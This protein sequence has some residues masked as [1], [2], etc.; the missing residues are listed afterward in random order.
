M[1]P[2]PRPRHLASRRTAEGG[3]RAFADGRAFRPELH[4]VRGLALTLVVLF[5][6]LG[7]GR[8]SG[9]ID[10]FLAVTGFLAFP[11]LLRRSDHRGAVR[12]GPRFSGLVRRLLVPAVPVL[13]FVTIAGFLLLPTSA[14]P[15]LL[16]EVRASALF[17]E[18]WELVWSQ[19]AYGAAGPG[20]SPLQ[21]FWSLS[22]QGQFHVVAPLIVMAVTV[23]LVRRGR[24]P[25]RALVRVLTAVSLLSFAW[26]V[27]ATGQNQQA[28]YFSTFARAWELTAPGAVALALPRWR[29]SARWRLV[30]GW[31][32]LALIV[33]CGFALDGGRVF[34]GYLALWPVLGVLL[35]L[36]GGESRHPWGADV[37]LSS[38]PLAAV[39]DISYSLYLWHWPILILTLAARGHTSATATDAVAVIALSVAVAIASTALVERRLVSWT[40]LFGAT[41]RTL[42]VGA[43]VVALTLVATTTSIQR[44]H[45]DVEV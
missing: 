27:W 16:A 43:A 20:T 36:V 7:D 40:P 12:L 11:A 42:V 18:N 2:S 23:P 28:A 14:R 15:Q 8:V 24:D 29:I 44:L 39:A 38:R 26:S 5:H 19:L 32:G 30:L 22:V 45:G 10:V 25:R 31:T 1:S 35:V 6:V 4:G 17:Y 37:L 33:S 13:V 3:P 41:P 21:H 34:P 9:G